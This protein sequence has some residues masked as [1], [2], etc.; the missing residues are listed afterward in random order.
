MKMTP[1]ANTQQRGAVLL[2][3]LVFLV[4]LAVMGL[5]SMRT[6][7]L[8][9]RMAGNDADRANAHQIAQAMIDAVV[10][11]PA[12]TPVIGTVG[13]T[14]CTPG[15]PNCN[16]DSIF[17]PAGP[18]A[19]EVGAGHLSATA[20]LI[21]AGAAPPG[22]GYSSDFDGAYYSVTATYDRS[23][24]GLGNTSVTQGLVVITQKPF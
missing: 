16:L 2:V 10:A 12:M 15:Q 14:V 23:D 19:G 24:E 4:V 22:M 17:M 6:A 9:L 7:K 11:T 8:E 21:S 1:I 13:F 5:S 3:T 20:Q 18:L